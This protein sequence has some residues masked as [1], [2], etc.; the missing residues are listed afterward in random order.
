M[1]HL[2]RILAGLYIRS[3]YTAVINFNERIILHLGVLT[4]VIVLSTPTQIVDHENG[5]DAET[6]VER[7]DQTEDFTGFLS[8]DVR[9]LSYVKLMP[10]TGR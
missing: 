8:S 7:V 3:S 10:F 1:L 6:L 4:N 5:K 9:A 2:G